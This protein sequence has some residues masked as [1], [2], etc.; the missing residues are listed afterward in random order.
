PRS[1]AHLCG[2]R[3]GGLPYHGDRGPHLLPP[4][5]SPRRSSGRRRAGNRSQ[6]PCTRCSFA[7]LHCSSHR[8][9]RYPLRPLPAADRCRGRI[10]SSRPP[11]ARRPRCRRGPSRTARRQLPPDREPRARHIRPEARGEP[12]RA[13]RFVEE[14]PLDRRVAIWP[15]CIRITL[16][17]ILLHRSEEH[18]SE[19]QS[20]AYLV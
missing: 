20:L 12:Q 19:L 6:S 17:R 2:K 3:R 11:A 4:G 14:Y 5:A 15:P 18:T 1:L 8:I 10:A 9:V 16:E 13:T 7:D